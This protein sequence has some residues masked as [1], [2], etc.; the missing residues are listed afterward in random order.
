MKTGQI[1]DV[2]LILEGTYPFVAG[3]V[4]SWVHGLILGMPDLSFGLIFLGASN[5]RREKKYTL[6]PNVTFL[7]E[8][9][10]FEYLPDSFP[11]LKKKSRRHREKAIAAV[12]QF[13]LDLLDGH[14]ASFD[15]VFEV[16][17]AG[18]LSIRDLA[19]S[20]LSWKLLKKVYDTRAGELSF[21]DFFWTWRYTTLPL[22]NL[23]Y[24]RI[25]PARL[26][27][28]I[29]TGWA[30]YLGV[31]TK[32][33]YNVPLL[34]TE[35]GIYL[36]ERRIEISNSDWLDIKTKED[37]L[38]I[39]TDMGHFK[40]MWIGLF[41][42]MVKLCYDHCDAIFTLHDG[43]RQMQINS[44]ASPNLIEVIPN[45]VDVK[46]LTPRS[47][48]RKAR[49]GGKE[50]KRTFRIGFVGRVV[51]I[52][53]VKTLI[54]ACRRVIDEL[55]D[56][57]VL[58][59]GPTDEDEEYFTECQSLV[60]LLQLGSKLRF[61]GRVNVHKFYPT[62]DVQVL[63]SIS[64]GQPLVILEGYCYGVPVVATSVGACQEMIEGVSLEDRALGPSGFVTRI[65]S[66]EETAGALLKILHNPALRGQMAESSRQRVRRFYDYSRMIARYRDIYETHR[67]GSQPELHQ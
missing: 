65:G 61:L 39:H 38:A 24:P 51:P 57:E 12:E 19:Y 35:H 2:V 48:S 37:D 41:N 34:L 45:G 18:I 6:P 21:I 49:A 63:T 25:P 7:F 8:I 1:V 22:L 42:S 20:G 17:S 47:E 62:L 28:S 36:N 26:Y 4:S 46:K 5:E 53:D 23:F 27:H 33:R 43:N 59:M 13:C 9:D 30:G 29:C 56:T 60:E 64:E 31:I 32:K 52:K 16:L 54:R 3:G 11:P 10:L 58:L 55:P 50:K 14:M 15:R 67:K 40:R 66:P 44:G